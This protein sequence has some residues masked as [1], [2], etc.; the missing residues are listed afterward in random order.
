M[1]ACRAVTKD[2]F[3]Q[4]CLREICYLAATNEIEVKAKHLPGVENRIPDLLSRWALGKQ[5]RE[6]FWLEVADNPVRQIHVDN[7][8]FR[9]S[10]KW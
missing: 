4:K 3:L 8:L 9:F 6:Q 5:F 1:P 7:K 10:H 2:S